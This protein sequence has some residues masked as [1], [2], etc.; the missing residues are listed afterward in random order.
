M[1]KVNLF[2]LHDQKVIARKGWLKYVHSTHIYKLLYI[3]SGKDTTLDLFSISN[4][5][6]LVYVEKKR[7][8]WTKSRGNLVKVDGK[9][10]SCWPRERMGK[11]DWNDWWILSSNPAQQLLLCCALF[12][13]CLHFIQNSNPDPVACALVEKWL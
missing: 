4:K 1:L 12:I 5:L 8:I 10:R 11:R 2:N 7:K 3:F 9:A 6:A 13:Y